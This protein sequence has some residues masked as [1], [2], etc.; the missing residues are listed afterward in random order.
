MRRVGQTIGMLLMV[1]SVGAANQVFAADG[2][3]SKQEFTPGSY[4]HMQFP[5]IDEQTLAGDHPVLNNNGDVIDFYGSCDET[6]TSMGQ[7]AAQR[8]DEQRRWDREYEDR[9]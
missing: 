3:I 7:V 2:V 4:C 6:P 1:S 9:R 8:R 5:A